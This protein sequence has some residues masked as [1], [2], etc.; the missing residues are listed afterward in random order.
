MRATAS[1]DERRPRWHHHWH[2]A[3]RLASC[4]V[5]RRSLTSCAL[6]SAEGSLRAASPRGITKRTNARKITRVRGQSLVQWNRP[7]YETPAIAKAIAQS[8]RIVRDVG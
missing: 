5:G 4:V 1:D 2:H 3:P 6:S 7:K 8:L